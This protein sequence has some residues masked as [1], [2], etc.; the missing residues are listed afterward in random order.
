MK[1]RPFESEYVL[2]NFVEYDPSRKKGDRIITMKQA[3]EKFI[4]QADELK[5][6]TNGRINKYKTGDNTATVAKLYQENETIIPDPIDILECEILEASTG[7]GLMWAENGYEGPAYCEDLKS[8][9]PSIMADSTFKVPIRKPEY[10]KLESL[11]EILSVGC[12]NV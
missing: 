2:I 4:R 1:K 3:Y 7:S 8:A 10:K 12:Y 5:A 11:P 9:Y 6:A